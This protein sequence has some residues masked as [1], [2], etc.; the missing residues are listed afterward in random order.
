M[1]MK[2]GEKILT[3]KNFRNKK[4]LKNKYNL[5]N[6]LYDI[7]SITT[8]AYVSRP[9]FILNNKNFFEGKVKGVVIPEERALDIDSKFDFDLAET[10]IKNKITSKEK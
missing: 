4:N 2:K 10:I 9:D 3:F 6:N 1:I 7:Y 8:V 5:R